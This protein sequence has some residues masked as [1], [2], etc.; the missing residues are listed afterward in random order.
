MKKKSFFWTAYLKYSLK[1]VE[2]P[3]GDGCE[4]SGREVARRVDGVAAVE[5]ERHPDRH[6]RQTHE[7]GD[8]TGGH[9]AVFGV[10]DSAN[11]HQQDCGAHDLKLF[12]FTIHRL[13]KEN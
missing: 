1:D 4:E 8:H 5:A 10:R 13:F 9:A 11:H 7:Q 6:H 12:I 3:A 2:G